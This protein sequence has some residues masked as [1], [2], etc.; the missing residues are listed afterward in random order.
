M[1]ASSDPRVR[2]V[3]ILI[4]PHPARADEWTD[5]DWRRFGNITLFGKV[6]VD[7]QARADYFD[8]LYYAGAVVGITTTAFLDAAIV[9]RPVM[10]FHADDLRYEHEDSVHFQYLLNVA[11]GLLTMAGSLEEHVSQLAQMLERPPASVM[12]RQRRFVEA[13]VRPRGMDVP[14]TGVV[15]EAL[16]TLKSSD[17]SHQVASMFGRMGLRVVSALAR[18]PRW[19]PLILDEREVATEARRHEKARLREEALARKARQ[20]AEKARRAAARRS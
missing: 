18:H 9:G 4:R 11:G 5:V 12:E 8:S 13:F 19:R 7:E 15:V 1:R 20:R 17:A 2:D 16:E 6:P 10:A 3:T 14:A